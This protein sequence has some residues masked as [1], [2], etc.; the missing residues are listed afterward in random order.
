MI[1]QVILFRSRKCMIF[2]SLYLSLL[3]LICFYVFNFRNVYCFQ[4]WF[5]VFTC[6]PITDSHMFPSLFTYH[7]FI[8]HH[9]FLQQFLRKCVC[10]AQEVLNSCAVDQKTRWFILL[11]KASSQIRKIWLWQSF[12]ENC[13]GQRR[14]SSSKFLERRLY[15]N[16]TCG[17]RY[18]AKTIL[19]GA[20][21]YI[22][23]Q[24]N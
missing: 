4:I 9:A 8:L 1:F 24:K 12:T 3:V 23:I 5:G 6:M 10:S 7:F 20:K 2:L 21:Y 14:P 19:S 22:I 15:C 11:T 16:V 17:S 18:C 13:S